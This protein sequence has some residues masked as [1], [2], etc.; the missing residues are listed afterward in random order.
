MI[1]TYIF[2]VAM[3]ILITIL[4]NT[5]T[6][7]VYTVTPDGHYNPSTKCYSCHN[8]QHY[9][10]NITKY[11]T[12]DT[13][14]VFL[15][16]LHHLHTDL[17]IQNVHDIS[18][19]GSTANG[20]TLDTA[21]IQCNSSVGI[22]M[23]NITNLTM[24]KLEV[25]KCRIKDNF[26]NIDHQTFIGL[27]M[28]L[29]HCYN[30]YLQNIAV[31][32]STQWYKC[33]ML[34]MNVLGISSF[35]NVSSHGIM[36]EY[37][38]KINFEN[39]HNKILLENYHI[40][41]SIKSKYFGS[42]ITINL[43]QTTYKVELEF[44]NVKFASLNATVNIAQSE[45]EFG[46]FIH[47]N[48]CTIENYN[49][50]HISFCVVSSIAHSYYE[51]YHQVTF[52]KCLLQYNKFLRFLL[53][54]GIMN[55]KLE[56]CIFKYNQFQVIKWIET[57]L[58]SSFTIS[59]TLF[60]TIT[61]NNDLIHAVNV[62]IYLEGP[63]IFR[64]LKVSRIFALGE[65]GTIN[66]QEYI[67]VSDNHV[68]YNDHI[69]YIIVQENTLINMSNNKYNARDERTYSISEFTAPCYY[70]YTAEGQNFDKIIKKIN[71]SV[72]FHNDAS[73]YSLRAAHCRWLPNSA[74]N[75]TKPIDINNAL[76]KTDL[77]LE[78]KKIV[79]YCYN[80]AQD[81][82]C[83]T[84]T[85]ATVYPGQTI[86]LSLV[87]HYLY[88][89]YT[90]FD[91]GW[92]NNY[93]FTVEINDDVLQPTACKIAKINELI[94]QIHYNSCTAINFTI[95]HNGV[96]NLQWCELFINIQST[97]DIDVYYINIL[98]CPTG[99]VYQNGMCICDPILKSILQ[100]TTCDINYQ[101]ILRPPDSWLSAVTINNSHQYHISP[102]CPLH[103]CLPH[104]SHFNFTTPNS[105]CQFN[106]SDLL[107]GQCQQELSTVFGYSL[108]QHCSNVYLFLV[109][110]I[111]VAGL[112]LILLMFILNLTVTDGDI[113]GFILY[114]NIISINSQVFFPQNSNYIN[115]VIAFISLGNLDLGIP[116]CFY[117]GMDDYAKMWLQLAFPAYLILIATLLIIASR[118]STKVQRITAC[119][120][121]PVLATLFLLSYTKIL[122]TVSSVLF[123]YSTITHLPSGHNTLVWA[124]DANVP[125][126]G[127][128]YTVLFIVCL[129]LFGIL[130][131]FN[132]VACFTKTAMRLKL[133]NHFKPLI[134][135]YQGPYNYKCYY[136]TGLMLVVRAI[137][138]GLSALD[139]N[140]NLTI[141]VIL[142]VLITLIQRSLK[143]F[144][145]KWKNL[146]EISFI[147]NLL[148][149]FVL[150]FG[151]Y[152]IPINI[153]ITIAAL[154]FSLIILHHSI[155]NIR[156]GVIMHKLKILI[157]MTTKWVSRSQN[158]SEHQTELKNTPPDQTYNYQE[159]RESL[160]GQ[161]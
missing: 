114:V 142:L 108:C 55:I 44:C 2:I 14:L 1:L 126:F 67:E 64:K 128:K 27:G 56:E 155:N 154:Q 42:P 106:R 147:L 133:I 117:N 146:H 49:S 95:V 30:I 58:L 120:A 82:D 119:R 28:V 6:H 159:F 89:A 127:L 26:L 52:T 138:F 111:A 79:C 29:S 144:K 85:L 115:P 69:Y 22:T 3:L 125:L 83:S 60:Y 80:S 139:T 75:A 152:K 160:I 16:G 54:S 116:V 97:H 112:V 84:E 110:P 21:I 41:P 136:W 45:N 103:Y 10:L 68:S 102:H 74:F 77:S 104:S 81:Q 131:S 66:C 132:A 129:I 78:Y 105:Q 59:N 13:Q 15:P 25:K 53:A 151:H 101:T 63:V 12:S 92:Y 86:F 141:G 91:Y 73:V 148:A 93:I 65:H 17:I 51:M 157:E 9:L 161:D 88:P 33:N 96:S 122:R 140:I 7:T 4:T 24:A 153:M 156:G 39:I 150:S 134:D 35:I 43:D 135:A 8:L 137:F 48:Q 109:I 71:I 32:K 94:Q 18:L 34:I 143:P 158:N 72:V 20:T 46:N 47:F 130:L 145:D 118:Y 5:V 40:L 90:K 107:C 124:V 11:F 121:L 36:I 31:Y 98:P 70:Q 99:F 62:Y 38:D 57:S 50:K 37:N 149:I 87:F 19:I 123:Y 100:I 113:N 61:C 23:S 76:I